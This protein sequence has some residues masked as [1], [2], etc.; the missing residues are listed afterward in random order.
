[1]T[2]ILCSSGAYTWFDDTTDHQSIL[3]YGPRIVADGV[4]IMV[5]H[6][7]YPKLEQIA[8]DL[9]QSCLS[10]PAVHADKHLGRGLGN[11]ELARRAEAILQFEQNC[12]LGQ[13]LGAH[14]ITLHLWEHPESD[15]Y[16]EINLAELPCLVDVA[17]RYGMHLAVETIPCDTYN[18]LSNILQAIERDERIRVTLDT[19]FLMAAGQLDAVFDCWQLWEQ[20]RVCHVHIKDWSPDG[21]RYLQP[22]KGVIDFATFFAQLHAHHFS[23]CFSLEAAACSQGHVDVSALNTSIEYLRNTWMQIEHA[24][25]THEGFDRS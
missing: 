8:N 20:E 17:E 18:P 6:S 19:E 13:R 4:E 14:I 16:L 25:L 24:V 22:R 1:M 3:T 23:G 10:F 7:F 12:W 2:P 21:Q 15:R 11:A 9:Q 5:H